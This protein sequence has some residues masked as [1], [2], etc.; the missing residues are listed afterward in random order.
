M[1]R[2]RV[3]FLF[4][5]IVFVIAD[6]KAQ[7]TWVDQVYIPD[8]PGIEHNPM[9]GWMPG[10]KG[11]NSDFPYSID[12]FYMPL[13]DVYLGWGECD[14]TDFEA[15]LDRIVGTGSHVVTR[16]FIDYPNRPSAMPGFLVDGDGYQV[17]MYDDNSP[18]WNDDT[19]MV[20]LEEFIEMF[21]ARYDGDPRIA[22]IEAGLYGFW[23][24][25]H[26][27]PENSW[28]MT[29]E[30][31]DRLL[32]AYDHAFDTTH[33]GLR[34]S[35][36]AS[37]YDLKMSVG[38]YDDSFAYN[39]LCTGSWCSW[40]G[41]LVPDG[42]TDNYKY[43]PF[44]GELR[45]QI[46]NNIFEAWP[47]DSYSAE[48][49]MIMEDLETCIRA[50]HLSFM[51]AYYLYNKIPTQTEFENALRAHKMMGYEF[52]VSSLQLNADHLSNVTV[53]LYIENRGVAPI[54][55]D[56]EVEFAAINSSGDFMGVFGTADWDIQ[57][58]FPDS[59][60]SLKTF[61]APVYGNDTYT[62]LMRFA[63]P[64]EVYTD[65]ARTLRFAN[66]KQDSDIDGWL[67]LGTLTIEADDVETTDIAIENCPADSIRVDEKHWLTASVSPFNATNKSVYWHSSDPGVASINSLGEMT[68]LATGSTTVTLYSHDS[69]LSNVCVVNVSDPA[70]W[71]FGDVARSLPGR[72]EGEHFD[73]GGEGIAYHDD[74]AKN[75]N[76]LFR[77]EVMVD[78]NTH[79]GASNDYVIGWTADGEWLEYT[80]NVESGLYDI[81]LLYHSGTNPG[82]LR[83]L[84]DNE[85]IITITEM[86]NQGNW[87]ISAKVRQQNIEI[88]GGENM[89]L[90]LEIIGQ[91]FDF[92]AIDFAFHVDAT[93]VSIGACPSV[94]LPIGI[95]H[96]L[97][98]SVEPPDASDRSVTW[99]SSNPDVATVTSYGMVSGIAEGTVTI[100]ATTVDGSFTDQC[101]ITV[102][103]PAVPV[104]G[105]ELSGC[106]ESELTIDGTVQLN[107][108]VSPDNADDTSVT[109]SS[110][111]IQI[112]S[113]D[114]GGLV[115]ATAPGTATIYAT[116]VDGGFTETCE[117][118]VEVPVVNVTGVTL[119]NCPGDTLLVDSV[120]QL[121]AAIA[122]EDADDKQLYWISS[123]ESVAIVDAD[124]LITA[125]SVG[126]TTITVTAND[127]GFS[128]KCNIIIDDKT[129]IIEYQ[130]ID[131][132]VKVY[133][134][135][136]QDK[137]FLE[138]TNSFAMKSIQ[139][140]DALGQIVYRASTHN[141]RVEIDVDGFSTQHFLIVRVSVGEKSR[142]F[143][144][145]ANAFGPEY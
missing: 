70:Q 107:A 6:M 123:D 87:G 142:Y 91:G 129:D 8:V 96:Q 105:V 122:P 85:E 116:T 80:V 60:A 53:D 103:K 90:R 128:D 113:V 84:L 56:W 15:E 62:I 138:F 64:L 140:S 41:N 26:T 20:A 99:S 143:K 141:D 12:H 2:K 110:S 34:Q 43:H 37:T 132:L 109:W 21:G 136:V 134:N 139:I 79:D 13:G 39:T 69:A 124:G 22:F 58:I 36:H 66:E 127:G 9:K 106:P 114:Q 81:T 77:P 71:P 102:T 101:N 38:Y 119:Q 133:P 115:T 108:E 1:A 135:P 52:F 17:P 54:Y 29:Q 131:E 45:P 104:T 117:I 46:Q 95:T 89:I 27:Y 97:T 7:P 30:N 19:L 76:M 86:E 72:I 68:A 33:I 75:G 25:W 92:D 121:M 40:N 74:E 61:T 82:N 144:I 59:A 35:N 94:D 23:G 32:I 78:F 3:I 42:I 125:L 31:K 50:T 24:E 130:S 18:H 98:A 120:Y 126:E 4:G 49:N 83:I 16:F 44:A 88:T 47:N 28:A 93:G 65:N 67:T 51:K 11:I 57:T 63:N 48:D 112:L 137:L 118:S 55:Y 14:W 5:F 73:E 100:T 111:D 10:Y 145:L